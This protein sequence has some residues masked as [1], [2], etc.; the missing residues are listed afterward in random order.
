MIQLLAEVI[1]Q[2]RNSGCDTVAGGVKYFVVAV[3]LC[4]QQANKDQTK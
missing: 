4:L 3:G 2:V 1:V